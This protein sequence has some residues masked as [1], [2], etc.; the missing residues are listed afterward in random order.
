MI[1]NPAGA[2]RPG[3]LDELALAQG[4][5]LAAHDPGDR[6]PGEEDDHDDRHAEPGAD[7]RHERDGEQQERQAQR[8]VDQPRQDAVDP[9][10]EEAGGEA[11][12][13]ADTH[14]GHR[15]DGADEDRDA[16][17]VGE[18]HEEIT[19]ELVGAQPE[20]GARTD[21]QPELGEP[22]VAVL[23]VDRVP[24][25]P[26]DQRRGEGEQDHQRR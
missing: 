26:G 6:A 19:A 23:L 25:P 22:G 10:A 14:G 20:L 16:C 24:G 12:R 11:D 3:R 15:R 21:G 7:E 4:E 1:R 17:A 5:H 8:R 18:A 9:A 13:R 2:E